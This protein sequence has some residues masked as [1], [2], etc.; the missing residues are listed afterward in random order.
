M[1]KNLTEEEEVELE[2]EAVFLKENDP[3][4]LYEG[5][6]GNARLRNK[7]VEMLQRKKDREA[8]Q[9]GSIRKTKRQGSRSIKVR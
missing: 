2:D 7:L 6:L 5:P 4:G 1:K 8:N 9:K 3:Y